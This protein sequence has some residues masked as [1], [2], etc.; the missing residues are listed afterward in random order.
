MS[1]TLFVD[2]IEPNLSSGVHIAGHVI[3]THWLPITTGFDTVTNGYV[4][5][6]STTFTPKFA[7]S[8]IV[9]EWSGHVY[10]Y[11]T[12]SGGNS[13]ARIQYAGSTIF[14]TSYITYGVPY[15]Y[16]YTGFARGATTSANTSAAA[17]SFE[18]S[19]GTQGRTYVYAST[20]GLFIQEIAQ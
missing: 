16:M 10:K 17:V 4:A 3:Q 11:N 12:N 14:L 20:G 1:S 18:I 8:R 9:V 7:G 13:P 5:Q 2:A 6:A 15:E 19:A